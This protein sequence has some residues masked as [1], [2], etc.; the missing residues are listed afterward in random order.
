VTEGQKAAVIHARAATAM[1]R[2]MGMQAENDQRKHRNEAMAYGEAD[3]AKV[4]EEEGTHWNAT[5]TVLY[6]P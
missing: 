5:Y 6:H 4:I 2:A 3:F 1:I